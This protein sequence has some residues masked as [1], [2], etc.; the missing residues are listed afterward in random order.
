MGQSLSPAVN[1]L[2][3]Q[4]GIDLGSQNRN[5]VSSG[6][7]VTWGSRSLR[8]NEYFWTPYGN[9]WHVER[10]KLDRSLASL[11]SRSGARIFC[12]ARV[13]SCSALPQRKW[14]LEFQADG[15]FQRLQCRFLVDATGRTGCPIL[16]RLA[17]TVVFD[18]L[19][20]I[21]WVGKSDQRYPYTLVEAVKHGWFYASVM[22]NLQ[23]TIVLMTDSDIYKANQHERLGFWHRQLRQAKHICEIFPEFVKS[24][25]QR[26]F[27]ASTILRTPSSGVNWLN[28]GDAAVS[29]DP[30]CGQGLYQAMAG[31]IRAA[32]VVEHY[33]RTGNPLRS[34]DG[35]AS[36]SFSRYL[37]LLG[38]YYSQ[39]QRWC[40]SAF[41][42][43]RHSGIAGPQ[44]K[45]WQLK[46]TAS[47][48]SPHSKSLSQCWAATM[49]W[50]PASG[51]PSK[52][53]RPDKKSQT[54][55]R[56]RFPAPWEADI[57]RHCG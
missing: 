18:R 52:S 26:A 12:R 9:G 46:S 36:R 7:A 53:Q 54:R 43:R 45:E 31:A 57:D 22:P 55:I 14:S 48:S 2:L 34:Y 6:V 37:T 17:R 4:I 47:R 13:S 28:I 44:I 39:E 19:I 49:T 11:A 41:W 10:P 24:Y 25:P 8:L 3:N 33:F 50:N 32:S 51:Q 42:E 30:I 35:W 40:R 56:E 23:S 20:G 5:L 15:V 1:P 21:T 27:S 29:Y 38:E 16:P